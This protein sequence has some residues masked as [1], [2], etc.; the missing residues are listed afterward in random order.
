MLMLA[1]TLQANI[2]FRL[3]MTSL[4]PYLR[5]QTP[6]QM[7]ARHRDHCRPPSSYCRLRQ[8]DRIRSST[9]LFARLAR[10]GNAVNLHA[11]ETNTHVVRHKRDPPVMVSTWAS[12]PEACNSPLPQENTF[13]TEWTLCTTVPEGQVFLHILYSKR[14]S[15]RQRSPTICMNKA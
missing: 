5:E 6:T 9:R 15:C 14:T 4:R 13:N 8:K 3:M 7:M 1:T 12:D 10:N 2:L 11:T